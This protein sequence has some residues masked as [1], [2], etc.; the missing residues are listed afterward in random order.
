MKG[1]PY[2][3]VA[4]HDLRVK[5]CIGVPKQERA[6]PQEVLISIWAEID[7]RPAAKSDDVKKSINYAD[8]A[9]DIQDLAG[10]ERKTIERFAE[11]IA[12]MALKKYRPDRVNV[13]IRKFSLPGAECA[14]IS[15]CRP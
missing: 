7:T 1:K 3:S 4:I 12:S 15:I 13:H 11:D 10:T 5:T 14:G 9:Q 6:K 2:S 8:L